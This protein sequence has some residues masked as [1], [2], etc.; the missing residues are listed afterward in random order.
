LL[1]LPIDGSKTLLTYQEVDAI[2]EKYAPRAIIP[3]HYLIKGLS[4]DVSGLQSAEDWV[5]SK[6]DVKRID[7]GEI[8]LNHAELSDAVRRVY[9]FGD[10]FKSK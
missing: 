8:V 2:I 3:A 5:K 7:G 10:G 6:R 1:V 4:T 9:Y